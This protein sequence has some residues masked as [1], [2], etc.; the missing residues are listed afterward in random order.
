[1]RPKGDPQ[2]G[3]IVEESWSA[4]GIPDP[5]P[6]P[7]PRPPTQHYVYYAPSRRLSA[8]GGAAAAR[9]VQAVLR[10]LAAAPEQLPFDVAEDA[11]LTLGEAGV[12]VHVA[13][14]LQHYADHPQQLP[15]AALDRLLS[16]YWCAGGA[17]GLA[18]HG[19][20]GGG[21]RGAP[22][23]AWLAAAAD[24]EAGLRAPLLAQRSLDPPDGFETATSSES[25][26]YRE[27]TVDIVLLGSAAAAGALVAAPAAVCSSAL[28]GGSPP[29]QQQRHQQQRQRQ[30]QRWQQHL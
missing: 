14:E 22:S 1:V 2:Q 15:T 19:S 8:P 26:S 3:C 21:T 25:G 7:H 9:R 29:H 27:P 4:G 20:G 28:G 6:H 24:E 5:H 23:A 13:K 10:A 17:P 11:L 12:D 30:Q 18:A 16:A